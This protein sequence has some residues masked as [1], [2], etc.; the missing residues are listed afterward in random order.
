MIL[1]I[2]SSKNTLVANSSIW[3]STRASLG[4]RHQSRSSMM[5]VEQTTISSCK[6]S[7]CSSNGH[8]SNVSVKLPVSA[9]THTK[10]TNTPQKVQAKN[11]ESSIGVD[12]ATSLMP[13][14]LTSEFLLCIA[15][16]TVHVQLSSSRSPN[17]AFFSRLA[18]SMIW[19]SPQN[20]RVPG[21]YCLSKLS[22][23]VAPTNRHLRSQ[24]Y[25]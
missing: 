1:G 5:I 14:Q 15:V 10:W 4:K 12:D 13:L 19:Q 22:S 25:A 23:W 18:I 20:T 3:H 7:Y 6:S 16:F 11:N 21:T 9:L 24:I 17:A 2:A 8:R